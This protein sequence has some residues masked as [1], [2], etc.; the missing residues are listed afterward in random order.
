MDIASALDAQGV[1]DVEGRGS[2][3]L[4]LFIPQ[5]LGWGCY[6]AIPCVDAHWVDVLHGADGNAVALGVPH[7]FKFDLLVPSHALFNEALCNPAGVKTHFTRLNELVLVF[8]NAAACAAQGI[9]WTDDEGISLCFGK[10]QSLFY[11]IY[12]GALDHRLSNGLHGLL[13]GLSVLCFFDG[14]HVC[15]QEL[16]AHLV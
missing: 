4:H 15:A 11:S 9:G 8:R 7:Y 5:R 12:N 13:K 6:D 16:Y 14:F 10:F 3:H 1:D 2:E